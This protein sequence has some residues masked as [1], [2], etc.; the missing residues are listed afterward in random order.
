[1][2]VVSSFVKDEKTGTV[3]AGTVSRSSVIET[4]AGA[5]VAYSCINKGYGHEEIRATIKHSGVVVSVLWV[6]VI[7][8]T[9]IPPMAV[10]AESSEAE[11]EAATDNTDNTDNK[12]GYL[13]FTLVSKPWLIGRGYALKCIED[14]VSQKLIELSHIKGTVRETQQDS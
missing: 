2:N 10:A 7:P 8:V 14:F 9:C 5:G 13:E 1:M 3:H 4:L 11:T 12:Y 6:S